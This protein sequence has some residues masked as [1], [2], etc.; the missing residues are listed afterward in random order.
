MRGLLRRDVRAPHAVALLEPQRVD[1]PV[2]ARDEPV[3]PAGLPQRVPERD[4]VLGGAVELPA[5]LP[6]VRHA[7]GEARHRADR[8]RL[9][10]HVRERGRREVG[11][12]QRLEDLARGR[13]PQAEAGVL[14]GHVGDVDGAVVRRM[15][16]DP[17]EVVLAE[18]RARDD[19]ESIVREP[20]HREVA[21]DP[22]ALVEHLGVRDAA[23]IAG[24]AVRAEALEERCR[25]LAGD[26]EL[27]EGRLVEQRGP[28]AACDV[29]GADGRRPEL[30][31]PPARAERLVACRRIRLEPVGALPPRLLPEDGTELGE[32]RIGGGDPQG[33][34]GAPLVPRVLHVVVGL[35]DLLRACE[36]V[37]LRAV[38][39]AETA[40]VHVPHV[41][42][43]GALDDPLGDELPHAAR[44]GEPVGAEARRD[45][46]PAHVG[47]AEDEL[48]IRRERL[49]AVHE[50]HDLHLLERRHADDRVLHQLLEARPVLLE[51]LAV[52]VRGDAVQR[53]RRTVPLVPA[54]DQPAG[55]RPEVDEERRVTH[56]RHVEREAAGLQ[57]EVLV[58]DGHDRHGDARERAE[59]AREH[60]TGVD[61]DLGLDRAPVR[62][63][64]RHPTALGRDARDARLR[65]DLRAAPSGPLRE[66]KGQL[67]RVDVAVAREVCRAEDALDRHR[68]EQLLR[69]RRRDE[70]ER[71]ADRLRPAR[72]ANDLLHPLLRGGEPQG[73]DLAPARLEPDFRTECPVELDALHHHPRQ[74]ER[75][76]ELADEAGGVER[77]A[78]RQVCALDE[79]DVRPAEA[80]EPVEDRAAAHA[81][82]DHD[83]PRPLLHTRSSLA[84]RL[85][86]GNLLGAPRSQPIQAPPFWSIAWPTTPRAS[87]ES[88]HA[89]VPATSSGCPMRPTGTAR[90]ASR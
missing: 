53:P 35:V 66:R 63:D 30:P 8:D 57:H 69:F 46:E 1:R 55:L 52:E 32:P 59:L 17:R 44:P 43:R 2:A 75:R 61:D 21:L 71:Q 15:L 82:A 54:H 50:T 72:L 40:R 51:E 28:L 25:A 11:A 65:R 26:V 86:V 5:E 84:A 90:I 9:R 16:A 31:G 12:R 79:E 33:P 42:R 60:P 39:R 77:R 18:R 49:G 74:R 56:R 81:A 68:R 41:E 70:L 19:P 62:L 38:G 83:R 48:T 23:D 89:T 6:D 34:P 80:R 20:R 13:P 47:W 85:V 78:A 64:R 14:R 36:R 29:L 76:A 27:R 37:R 88:S 4:A 24:D 45:P 22:A 58:R 67:A 73:A 3:L 87:G 7:D 10:G